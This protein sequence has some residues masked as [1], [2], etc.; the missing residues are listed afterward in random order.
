MMCLD[1][2]PLIH[3]KDG[4]S[5][6]ISARQKHHV[7]MKMQCYAQSSSVHETTQSFCIKHVE[8]TPR[9]WDLG[10]FLKCKKVNKLGKLEANSHQVH[11]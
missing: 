1:E 5:G 10:V 7:I 2:C 11:S 3:K 8:D 4:M 6:V 9:P